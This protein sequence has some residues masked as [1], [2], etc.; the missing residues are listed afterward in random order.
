MNGKLRKIF[1][2]EEKTNEVVWETA[3]Y[4]MESCIEL[5]CNFQL[6]HGHIQ[7]TIHPLFL[8]FSRVGYHMG[9]ALAETLDRVLDDAL[10]QI[11]GEVERNGVE[12]LRRIISSCVRSF[13]EVASSDSE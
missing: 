5:M 11:E 8:Y 3:V 13:E 7:S 6:D 9:C 4:N 2:E 1:L 10:L 12:A